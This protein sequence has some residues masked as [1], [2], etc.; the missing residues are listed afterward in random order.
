MKFV[1]LLFNPNHIGIKYFIITTGTF[2]QIAQYPPPPFSVN[3]ILIVLDPV[4][5]P[6]P[7]QCLEIP[8]YSLRN[9]QSDALFLSLQTQFLDL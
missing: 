5:Q 9:V 4:Y 1:D 8:T 2:C 6:R 7:M 3:S